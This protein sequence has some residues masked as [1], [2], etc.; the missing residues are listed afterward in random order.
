MHG[1]QDLCLP[2][3]TGLSS[4]RRELLPVED[5]IDIWRT[6]NNC[7]PYGTDVT[8]GDVRRRVWT[9]DAGST[10]ELVTVDGLAHS[11]AGSTMANPSCG[12]ETTMAV[13]TT[14][15]AWCFFQNHPM[16]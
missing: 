13:S 15:Q 8:D 10:V 6:L 2:Y 5:T 16:P 14:Q 9:C 11:W 1:L 3:D 7:S 4:T 12:V